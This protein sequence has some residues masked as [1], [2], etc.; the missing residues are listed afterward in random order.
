MDKNLIN[1]LSD[2]NKDIDNQKLMDY[3][4]G[5][6]SGADANEVEKMLLDSDFA[7]EAAEGLS[8]INEKNRLSR[9]IYELNANLKKQLKQKKKRRLRRKLKDQPVWAMMA[10]IF[11]I[12]VI[13]C[14][15]VIHFYLKGK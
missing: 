2:S 15:I 14:Y 6:L 13:L 11:F 4:S 10:L 8:M 12:L 5:K 7:N 9:M 1:I 3:L